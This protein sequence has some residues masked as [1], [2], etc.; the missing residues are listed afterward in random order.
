MAI[1]NNVTSDDLPWQVGL[2]AKLHGIVDWVGRKAS[3][4]IIPVVVVTCYDVVLRKMRF[5]TVWIV[6]NWGRLYM[7]ESTLLQET[8]WHLHTALFALVLGFGYIHNTH[9]RVDLVREHLAFRRKA[10]LEFIGCTLF[11]LPYCVIVIWFAAE[12]T[13]TSYQL[14][15]QSASMVGLPHRFLIKGVLTAGLCVAL[16]AGLAVWFQCWAVLF[17]PEDKR[18]PLYT[19]EWPEDAGSTHEGKQRLVL[20]ADGNVVNDILDEDGEK[21]VTQDAA[22]GQIKSSP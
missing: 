16:L 22:T 17:G 1:D 14:G 18:Y 13:I 12:Y 9:V 11:M 15:E 7:F 6:E 20:D 19:L 5:L 10:W 4:L 21:F 8:E 3:W 2:A